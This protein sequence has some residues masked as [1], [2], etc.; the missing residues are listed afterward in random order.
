VGKYTPDVKLI[1]FIVTPF[2]VSIAK[3]V[4]AMGN[5]NATRQLYPK[6]E[7][8]ATVFLNVEPICPIWP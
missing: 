2:S 4:V 1:S 7:S 3:P 5:E 8:S 6:Y